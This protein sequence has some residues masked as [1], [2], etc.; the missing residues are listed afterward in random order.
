MIAIK[1]LTLDLAI[2]LLPGIA[3]ACDEALALGA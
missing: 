1:R 2:A 3:Y